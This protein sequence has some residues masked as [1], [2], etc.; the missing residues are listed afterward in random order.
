MPLR[1]TLL[2][3]LL[4]L[5]AD[6]RGERPVPAYDPSLHVRPPTAR[7]FDGS[8]GPLMMDADFFERAERHRRDNPD[9]LRAPGDITLL[10]EVVVVQGDDT[11]ISSDGTTFG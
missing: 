5:A 7:G 3:V 10:G 1:R 6:A 11:T 2:A 9:V 4:C 8:V